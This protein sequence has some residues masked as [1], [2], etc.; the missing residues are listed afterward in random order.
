MY[1]PTP[2]EIEMLDDQMERAGEAL[3]FMRIAGLAGIVALISM[4]ICVYKLAH[5]NQ[6]WWWFLLATYV[7]M[8]I[9]DYMSKQAKTIYPEGFKKR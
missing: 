7:S 6:R 1:R 2:Q 9:G 8:G 4:G 5:D 3:G